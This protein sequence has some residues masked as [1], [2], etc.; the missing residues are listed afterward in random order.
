[1]KKI[2]FKKCFALTLA[3]YMVFTMNLS[4][5]SFA[6]DDPGRIDFYKA[7]AKSDKNIDMIGNRIYN[8][9]IYLPSD[10][11]ID[12]TPKATTFNMN[13]SSY[14]GNVIINVYKNIHNL[15]LEQIYAASLSKNASDP[16]YDYYSY[17]YKCSARI[18]TD[19]RN[20]RYISITSVTPEYSYYGPSNT[21]EEKGTYSEERTYIGK[22]NDVNYIYKVIIS[23]DLPFYKQHQNLFY[24][25]ADSFRTSFDSSNPNIKDLSDLATSYR[26][27]E[28]KIY[29]WKIEL[30]PYWKLQNQETATTVMFKPLYSSEEIGSKSQSVDKSANSENNN[31]SDPSTPPNDTENTQ[32]QNNEET[33]QN[34]DTTDVNN[35]T[36][37]SE[38][39]TTETQTA[40]ADQ[41]AADSKVEKIT[42]S[43]VVSFVSSVPTNESFSAWTQKEFYTIRSKYNKALFSEYDVDQ[44]LIGYNP[45][46]EIIVYKTKD[47]SRD[48]FTEGI[49]L[50]QG[51]GYRYKVTL[52]MSDSKFN[53]T[54]GKNSFYRMLRSFSL[55]NK[56]SSFVKEVLPSETFLDPDSP[57]VISLKNFYL[58]ISADNNWIEPFDIGE[59]QL[60]DY[61]YYSELDSSDEDNSTE[62]L[63]VNHSASGAILSIN[64]SITD[65][66]DDDWKT[67]Y[68]DNQYSSTDPILNRQ[69]F[70]S[71]YQDVLV[72][73]VIEKYDINKMEEESKADTR[74]Y[75]NYKT[76]L[77]TY[78][79]M[80]KSGKE[81][82][83]LVFT[84]PVLNSSEENEKLIEEFWGKV[85]VNNV[86]LGNG[87]KN[88]SSVELIE[89]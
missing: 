14:K 25:L 27:F 18:Q 64:A 35:D 57:K 88:W 16:Y 2:N 51:N 89:Q 67:S 54:A 13:T 81:E 42:D 23:M 45:N 61:G 41:T 37:T 33:E 31:N 20:N 7:F 43:L 86:D 30:A 26:T 78:T 55:T 39:L 48:V 56:K 53:E 50:F 87:I 59:G 9:S 4:L 60:E 49:M 12:K 79:Y 11:V 3:V 22:N 28:S 47:N 17:D 36:T 63:T 84:L 1:M 5:I 80:L 71:D 75:Y 21:D 66:T 68:V 70:F 29:G 8:W 77:N 15:S 38:Q 24:K 73:K 65:Q 19:N 52:R 85:L 32:T 44:A 82:Y 83:R 10:A 62:Q 40:E 34:K 58:K 74:K 69:V 6:K 76:L 72:C 46:K